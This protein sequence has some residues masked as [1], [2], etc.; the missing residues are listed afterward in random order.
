MSYYTMALYFWSTVFAAGLTV[1]ALAALVRETRKAIDV[2]KDDV[3][4]SRPSF[5]HHSA[6]SHPGY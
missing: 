1:P 5:S 2:M 4:I 3:A 6:P